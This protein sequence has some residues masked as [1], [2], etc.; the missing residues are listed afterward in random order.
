LT[1]CTKGTS[2]VHRAP[3]DAPNPTSYDFA[4][5]LGDAHE[6][7]KE[8]FEAADAPEAVFGRRP[9]SEPGSDDVQYAHSFSVEDA[10][11]PIFSRAIFEDRANANDIYVHTF[12]DPIAA[13]SV[14]RGRRGGLPF[15]GAFQIHMTALDERHTRIAVVAHDTE[16]VN[17]MAWGIGSCG[18]GYA[19]RYE[20][21]PATTVEEYA[22][23]RHLA[24]ALGVVDL[25]PARVPSRR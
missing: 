11:A 18:P 7:V 5:P 9:S 20:P 17:G 4:V 22:M 3:L 23:L 1:A 16:I 21:V 10:S 15:I 25:P 6:R 19:W 12:H 8:A 14:Y 2:V 24:T 13:S